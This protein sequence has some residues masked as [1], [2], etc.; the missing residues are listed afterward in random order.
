[1]LPHRS[2]LYI[3][4]VLSISVTSAF[5]Q[6]VPDAGSLLQQ[7]E[8]GR[9]APPPGKPG[10]LLAPP[11]QPMKELSGMSVTVSR[12]QFAGNT[13]LTEAQLAPAVA[14][15][16]NR[17]LSF[18]DLQ[19]AAAAVAE[20]Y[21]KAGWIVRVY[22]PLQEIKDGVVTL[23]VVEAVFGQVRME[24]TA[25]TR[26][27]FDRLVPIVAATQPHGAA[28]K[29]QAMD[30][31][32]L[33]LDDM[34]GISTAGSLAPGE[35]ANE[36]DLVLKVEDE[37]LINGQVGID[38]AS[39]RST[40]SARLTADLYINS[41]LRFGDQ[42]VVNLMHT[43]GSDYARLAYTV[44][45]GAAGWRV[46][47]NVSHLRYRLVDDALA[48]LDASG[49][50]T[51]S[52]VEA[53]YPLIRARLKNLYLALNY[54]NKRFDNRAAATTITDYKID[55]FTIGLNGNVLDQ[56]GGGGSN[57]ASLALV[58]GK[59]DLD[60]S[61]N[62]RADAL[63][64]R[65]GGSFSKLRYAASRQQVL[66]EAL[67]LYAAF[68]G[69]TAGKN[70]DS[71]E[72]FYL[73]GAYGVRA[74]PSNEGGGSE[75]QLFNLELRARLPNNVNVTGFYDWGHVKVNHDNHFPGAPALGS[76]SLKGAGLSVAWLA[77][78][79][80]NLKATWARR[81]G[82]NPNP[83]LTGTDQDGSFRKNRFWLQATM[84]F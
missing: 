56:Y 73:G 52:G 30:R 3:L 66:T 38:N 16:V 27:P 63:T 36:V 10:P 48:A 81:I 13:L 6:T 64:T 42:A 15:F 12:F 71:A 67:A 40:G 33:L 17:P 45:L 47:A 41:P 84:P 34:P 21:R 23:Q 80:L 51:T 18:N 69:Q 11:P 74:Y 65:T 76:Y 54:D 2:P 26:V 31:A 46:G 60:G 62:A 14:S 57:S 35:Q 28:L 75:G 20:T 32:L 4:T 83:T 49:T 78:F 8:K 43:E 1:M 7:I 39:A 9:L 59:V 68:S 24:G 79:G 72:K 70:L 77:S 82:D 22:L 37:K 61:P 29:A 58:H 44:P 19:N 5:A 25:P 53:T 55:T 50:S